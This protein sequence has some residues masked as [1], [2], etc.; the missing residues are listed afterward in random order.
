M[1]AFGVGGTIRTTLT[2]AGE[3]AKRHEVEIVSVYRTRTTPAL[4]VPA[5]VRLRSLTDLRPETLD[6]LAAGRGLGARCRHWAAD[7]PSRIMSPYDIRYRTFNLLTDANL[8]RYL[9]SVR[10]GVLI[11]TRP[12]INLAIAR[13]AAPSVVRV[14]QDHLN[15]K[16]YAPE[17]RDEIARAY[18]RLDLVS[19]L[20]E[21]D[22]RA[23]RR[24]LRGRT[25]VE[26][27]PN[28]V[29]SLG[30]PRAALDAK[31]VVAAG[32]LTRQKGFDRLLRVW[33]T[34]ADQHPD[35]ELRIFGDGH[36]SRRLGR[37]IARLGIGDSARLMGYTPSLQDEL[38]SASIYVMSSRRE[39]FPMVLL[40][41][42]SVG[43]PV[44]SFDCPTGPRDI[45]REGVDGH[46]VPNGNR[47]ALAAALGG[48]MAD[49]DRRKAFGAAAVE[50]AARY[51]IVRIAER[52]E[53]LLADLA[54]KKEP[55]GSAVGGPAL[56]LIARV[57]KARARK[58]LR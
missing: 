24:L 7:R 23:Y 50:G 31:V 44:V 13:L 32:R 36:A 55:H 22:A 30:Q 26:C 35:W 19:S 2:T 6:R 34:V 47:H 58:L 42:M 33:A 53:S 39:G 37:Q 49:P 12:A 45:V 11:G 46:V 51:D 43:L 20:T 41:A 29:A 40:E 8:L 10:D 17:L 14:G 28:G 21:R 48:L 16:S 57:A 38:A 56:R 3:L 9:L 1:N 25:R 5:G 52:W 4:P 15:V 18:P 27:M 54:A